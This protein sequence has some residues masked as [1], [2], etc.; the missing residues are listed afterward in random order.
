MQEKLKSFTETLNLPLT[1]QS[2]ILAVIAALLLIPALFTPIW[3]LNFWAQ[4]YPEGLELFIY[5]GKM[6]GG[7]GGN[8]LTEINVL[9]HYIGM[10]ELREEDFNEF[11]WIPLVI[12]LM[13]VLTLRAAVMGLLS[14]LIDIIV[15]TLYFAGFAMWRFWYML[16]NYGHNLDPRAAVKVD[17]F[18]PPVFGTKMVGQFTVGSYPAAGVFL[19]LLFGLLLIAGIYLTFKLKKGIQL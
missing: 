17:P 14:S 3:H 13:I 7:N 5:P 12:G 8:D 10:A 15:F 6:V 4:Q 11:K 19:F 1:I 18:T 9:N 2:R 16:Y